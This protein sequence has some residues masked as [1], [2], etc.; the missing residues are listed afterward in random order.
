[1]GHVAVQ[2]GIPHDGGNGRCSRLGGGGGGGGS[3]LAMIPDDG[4]SPDEHE[5]LVAQDEIGVVQSAAGRGERRLIWGETT[6]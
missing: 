1:M 2:A 6:D 3:G 4:P 5:V